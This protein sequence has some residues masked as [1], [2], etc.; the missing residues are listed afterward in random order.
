[1]IRKVAVY[2]GSS[3]GNSPKWAEM[4]HSLGKAL[5]E[6]G[7][8]VIYG[9]A[10]VGL[11]KV[12][13]DAVLEYRGQLTGVFPTGF[14]GKREVMVHNIDVERHDCT[15]M[16]YV[17]DFA[18][19]KNTM[20]ELSDCAIV[21]PGGFGSMDELF[22][23]A[24]GNEIARHDKIS[25]VLNYDGYYDFLREQVGKM[26]QE[27]FLPKEC[28]SIVFVDTVAELLEIIS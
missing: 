8:E 5:A 23:F 22:C 17:R 13:A 25:Y 2:L 12:L 4:T 7:K 11:M 26:K 20:E 9:G 18:E 6:K 1:M 28:D 19:R 24:V 21:L 15:E 3:T 14:G 27:G 16:I 10:N